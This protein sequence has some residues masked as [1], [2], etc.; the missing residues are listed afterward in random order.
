MVRLET[1]SESTPIDVAIHAVDDLSPII[2]EGD[3]SVKHIGV[4]FIYAQGDPGLNF[5]M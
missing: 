5:P 4:D 2:V 3:Y 1:I